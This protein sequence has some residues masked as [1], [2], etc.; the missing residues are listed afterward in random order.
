LRILSPSTPPPST[1]PP[2]PILPGIRSIHRR[3]TWHRCRSWTSRYGIQTGPAIS[4][5]PST[6]TRRSA[7]SSRGSIIITEMGMPAA[8]A[9]VLRGRSRRRRARCASWC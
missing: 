3:S 9:A 1:S 4:S 2:R 6:D 5:R 8:A 7:T